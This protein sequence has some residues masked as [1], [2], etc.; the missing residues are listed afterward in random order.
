MT[1][2]IGHLST[3]YH[4][5]LLLQARE[6][7]PA[8]LG[9]EVAWRLFGTGPAIV[10]A[11]E[12]GELDLAYIGLPPAIVGIARGVPLVC[13]AG[14]H[15]EGTV[16]AGATRYLGHPELPDLGAVLR[17]FAGRAIGVPGTGSIHDVILRDALE[18]FG[19][20]GQ[21]RVV[22]Y[23]W[24]DLV[25]EAVAAGEVDGAVGTP[26]LAVAI[27]H[28]AG[29]RILFPPGALWP[30]NPS[31]GIVVARP[32]L[33]AGRPLVS[34]FLALHEE[35]SA[36]LRDDPAGAARDVAAHIGV[37]DAEFVLETLRVSPHYCAQ[38]TPEYVG[39][40]LALAAALRRL[41]YVA[42]DVAADEIFDRTLIDAVHPEGAH[43]R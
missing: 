32:F 38:L 30:S 28:F 27:R 16:L 33:A 31:C 7:A 24:A 36:V 8:R 10:A 14:G 26:A 22:N 12:R 35:A 6:L 5:S 37:V 29:G 40:T 17:Q 23:P 21:V 19:L 2:R 41:G 18:R 42:R 11:F 39:A 15:V 34:R 4:T 25:T 3:L 1:V 13:V 43:Y 9:T 20:A